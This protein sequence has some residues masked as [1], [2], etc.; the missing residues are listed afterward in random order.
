MDGSKTTQVSSSTAMQ[1]HIGEITRPTFI[2]GI[3]SPPT[4]STSNNVKGKGMQLGGKSH[5]IAAHVNLAVQLAEEAAASTTTLE[6][7]LWGTDDLIDVNADED[8][9]GKWSLLHSKT[10]SNLVCKVALKPD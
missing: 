8:D 5:A 9:W 3:Q 6:G 2:V 10:K 1:N 7:N 4:I